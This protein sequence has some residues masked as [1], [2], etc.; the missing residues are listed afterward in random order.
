MFSSLSELTAL[1][2]AAQVKIGLFC[3]TPSVELAR[4]MPTKQAM[5]ML[6]TGDLMSAQQVRFFLH[7]TSSINKVEG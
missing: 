5:E 2:P 7:S 3:T 4:V 6:L 1:S